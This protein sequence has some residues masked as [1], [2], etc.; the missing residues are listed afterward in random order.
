MDIRIQQ[1]AV[2]LCLAEAEL[3]AAGRA[4]TEEHEIAFGE[5]RATL[6][7]MSAATVISVVANLRRAGLPLVWNFS[8]LSHPERPAPDKNV[9]RFN[10]RRNAR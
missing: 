10:D 7:C 2:R 3:R 9:V 4:L 6:N 1:K 8:E 5:A